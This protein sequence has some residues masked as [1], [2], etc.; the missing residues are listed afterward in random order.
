[1]VRVC[2]PP[3]LSL[4]NSFNMYMNVFKSSIAR[5]GSLLLVVDAWNNPTALKRA[6][7]VT[8]C[9]LFLHVHG[10]AVP[11]DAMLGTGAC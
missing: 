10:C 6:W 9:S 5:I 2:I 11:F 3:T 8:C 4:C 1:M 7:C